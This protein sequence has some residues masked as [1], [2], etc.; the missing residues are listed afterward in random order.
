MKTGIITQARTTSTRL[1]GKVL[2]EVNG[3]TLLQ[4]HI[5]RLAWSN[6][7]MYVA[8]TVNKTDDSI[9]EFCK[10]AGIDYFRGDEKNV[11]SRFYLCALHFR[12]DVIVR[13]TSDCPLIDGGLISKAMQQ[14]L[15]WNDMNIY[16]S[17]C[18]QRTFPRGFDFEIFSFSAL[19]DA[20][21]N[22]KE[23][24]D[25][26]HVTPFINHNKSEK[27]QLKHFLN[28]TD[29]S[30]FNISVDT[31]G[32]FDRV[33]KL[34]SEFNCEKKSAAEIIAVLSSASV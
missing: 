3:K 29:E 13:V 9:S 15:A 23:P 8:T 25:L 11:L 12:L 32:D 33:K 27:I 2:L 14:Y 17:N 4:H 5:E 34:I 6:L 10:N 31:S 16:Y 19:D 28:D 1:P 30:R 18:L 26:E 7:P 22:A 24:Y 20:Y 21:Q